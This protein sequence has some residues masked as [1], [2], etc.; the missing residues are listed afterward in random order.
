LSV[1]RNDVDYLLR[2]LNRYLESPARPDQ[3]V[4]GTAGARPLV[5]SGAS[6][7]TKKL[8]RDHVVERD[9]RSGLISILGGKWTTHRAMAEDTINAVEQQLGQSGRPCE[10]WTLTL[11]GTEGYSAALWR[12][13]LKEFPVSE[14]TARHLSEKYGARAIG[15]LSK[16]KSEAQLLEPL[17]PEL[18]PIKAEVVYAA[19]DEMA[20]TIEDVLARRIGLQWYGWKEAIEAAPG[21]AKLLGRELGWSGDETQNAL[22]RYIEKIQA[23]R[24]GAGLAEPA[25]KG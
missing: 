9:E 10:T 7:A 22:S 4:S 1:T 24:M 5:S 16:A 2:H 18:A 12:T 15:V 11:A 19:S 23:A 25:T 21:V 20:M 14:E 17:I 13:F 6:K 8:A 3:I